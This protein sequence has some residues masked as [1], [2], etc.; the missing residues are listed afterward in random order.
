MNI[1]DI[2]KERLNVQHKIDESKSM[3]ERNKLGQY[4][5][6]PGLASEIVDFVLTIRKKMGKKDEVIRFLEPAIGTGS[7]YSALLQKIDNEQVEIALGIEKDEEIV[8]YSQNLWRGWNLDIRNGDF[9]QEVNSKDLFNLLI[10]NPPY[11][12]HHHLDKDYKELLKNAVK[13]QLDLNISGLAGLYCYFILLSHKWL[14]NDSIAAWLIPSEF[15]DVNY[16]RVIRSYL[17]E[18]VTVTHIH[19]YDPK[20]LRFDDALVTSSVV[21]YQKK[22]P[23][24]LDMVTFSFGGSPKKPLITKTVSIGELKK[25]DKWT[26]FLTPNSTEENNKEDQTYSILSEFFDIKRGIATGNNEFFILSKDDAV[27]KGIPFE[28]LRP[29]LPPPR[30]LKNDIIESGENGYPL[31]NENLVVI[32]CDLP[33]EI[34]QERYPDFWEYLQKGK[35]LGVANGYL[36]SKRKIWYSQ[37]KRQP[38]PFLCTYMGRGEGDSNPFR[39]IWNKSQAIATNVFLLLYPKGSL[40]K[41]LNNDPLLY[42]AVFNALQSIGH[43]QFIKAGR[44]YGGGLKKV[45]PKELGKISAKKLARIMGVQESEQPQQLTL[46]L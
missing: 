44:E 32:D 43:E 34:I 19:K 31:L 26:V 7:F 30:I 1:Y 46:L 18:K 9:T 40:K 3:V 13:E 15:M 28:C 25:I 27:Q 8:N 11:V 5:T 45:E 4:A 14:E 39:F 33:E 17:T 20:D 36:T 22:T 23:C 42:E 24:D 35:E 37:E 41:A 16:G 12:R 10:T 29:I 38:A 21:V 2:E 6:P